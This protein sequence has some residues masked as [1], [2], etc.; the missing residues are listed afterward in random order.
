MRSYTSVSCY[1]LITAVMGL[2]QAIQAADTTVAPATTPAGQT[3][4]AGEAATKEASL[5]ATQGAKDEIPWLIPYTDYRG[6]LWNR[7]ALTG[8]WFGLRQDLMDHG[9]RLDVSL[10]QI[11]QR[12]LSGGTKYEGSY[13][14][15][16]DILF[17]LDTDKA[18]LWPGGWFR[19]K[20][21]ARYGQDNNFNTGAIMPVNFDA[22]YPVPGRDEI[23]LSE[24]N[25]TQFLA[26]WVGVTLGRYSP[27]DANVFAHDE[28]E[29][30]LNTAFNINPVM[31]T[32]IPQTF[33]GAGVVLLPMKDV[34]LTTLV[35]DSEGKGDEYGF[36]TAFERGTSIFQQLEVGIK[37]FGL[38]GHQR[39]GWTWSDKSRV[40]LEQV[41]SDI[42]L[43]WI[44]YR[45]GL[46]DMPTLA[47]RGSD[48]SFFY[49]FDQYLYV[50]PGSKDRGIGVFGRFGMTDGVV[51]PIGSFYSLGVSGKGMIPGRDN[52]T[53]GV[54]YYYL[55]VSDKLGPI[56]SKLA[57]DEQGVEIYYNLAVTPWLHIT[58]DL[59][60]IDPA[61]KSV[62]TTVVAGIRMKIDF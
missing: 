27:R 49:D 53:F 55:A 38:P 28:T 17:Q 3:A 41:T 9:M 6:D 59:Q 4:A 19:V 25:F 24:F 37:P 29:Q 8:D 43:D 13:Q 11:L 51:S 57:N 33:L 46:G 23:E 30:F 52:D 58:P 2:G 54:G 60:I 44:K 47:H 34:M 45:L 35:L 48:W 42:V 20:G 62:D 15:G 18:G 16:L 14:G 36:D 22:L 50:V 5:P 7:P 21:E 56:L 12:N 31:L 1:L 39:I 40:R 32:T 61:R 26:T 10:T